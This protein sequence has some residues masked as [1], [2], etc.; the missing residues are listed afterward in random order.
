V[1]AARKLSEFRVMGRGR[2]RVMVRVRVGLGAK[3]R[4]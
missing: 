3:V 2:V 1:S 4:C